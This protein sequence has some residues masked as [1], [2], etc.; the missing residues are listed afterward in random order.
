MS[1][2][3]SPQLLLT[4]NT[5]TFPW[6]TTV[7]NPDMVDVGG[8]YFLMFSTGAYN[9][10]S[11]SQTYAECAGPTGPCIQSQSAPLLSNTATAAGP[12]GGS[13]FQ[14]AAGNWYLG[15]AAWQPGCTDY[16]CGGARRLFVAPATITPGSLPTP[17]T[18]MASTPTGDGYWLVNDQGG[19][20]GHGTEGRVTEVE[21]GQLQPAVGPPNARSGTT[22]LCRASSGPPTPSPTTAGSPSSID[23]LDRFTGPSLCSALRTRARLIGGGRTT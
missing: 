17:V 6:E 20:T 1:L 21:I 2:I 19:I 22:H 13:L 14:D 3:G 5:G 11:Y 23:P 16:S 9:S 18:G 15:Y 10:T 8:T 4:Q 7:E 12:G